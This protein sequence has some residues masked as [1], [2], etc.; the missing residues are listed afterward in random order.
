[1]VYLIL[2]QVFTGYTLPP[3]PLAMDIM[4]Q[5]SLFEIKKPLKTYGKRGP[6]ST[7]EQIESRPVK[8]YDIPSQKK[9]VILNSKSEN[10]TSILPIPSG[11]KTHIIYFHSELNQFEI[12]V[13]HVNI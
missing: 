13:F 9:T 6:A 3:D 12:M 2:Q 7:L 11:K 4:P 1:M 10:P 5:M 8:V